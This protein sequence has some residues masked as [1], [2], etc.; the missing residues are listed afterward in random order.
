MNWLRALV[1]RLMRRLG[2][3]RDRPRRGQDGSDIY[4][5]W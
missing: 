4:P 2:W 5:L 1:D 3:K